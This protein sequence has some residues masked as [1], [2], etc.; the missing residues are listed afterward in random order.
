MS[1]GKALGLLCFL[2]LLGAI[3]WYLGFKPGRHSPHEESKAHPPPVQTAGKEVGT[4]PSADAKAVSG[5]E[6]ESDWGWTNRVPAELRGAALK[7]A[8]KLADITAAANVPI[9]FYGALQDQNGAP[10]EGATIRAAYNRWTIPDVVQGSPSRATNDFYSD[11]AGR[12][13][14]SGITGETMTISIEK[15]G[16]ELEPHAK[17]SF[18]FGYGTPE[19]HEANPTN[20][21][22]YHLWK[23]MGGASL[24]GRSFDRTV[25]VDGTSVS[26]DL[27][28]EQFLGN[29]G[30]KTVVGA[31]IPPG[32]TLRIWREPAFFDPQRTRP[33]AWRY[34]L[35]WPKGK[36]QSTD[37]ALCYLAPSS[38]YGEKLEMSTHAEDRDF[39]LRD[40][41]AFYFVDPAGRYG[42][43]SLEVWA[44]YGETTAL[45]TL[46]VFWNPDGSRNLE[47][48]EH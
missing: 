44:D 28:N 33:T 48:E 16:Y 15:E 36:F 35:T 41:R 18:G 17:M 13:L 27:V 24:V 6:G 25:P 19:H 47:P 9:V 12:F 31:E 42:R 40:K 2:V 38:G 32:P 34:E 29:N 10:V 4:E 26:L 45:A 23:R 20:P 46:Y 3:A 43:G 30:W 5:T 22:V 8:K 37:D 1:K 39:R 21:V 14:I 7:R 11:A